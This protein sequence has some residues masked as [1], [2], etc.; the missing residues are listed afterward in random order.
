MREN[1]YE[2]AA[3]LFSQ[4]FHLLIFLYEA[5]V[6][7]LRSLYFQVVQAHEKLLYEIL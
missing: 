1:L 3:I 4:L 6:A 5:L 2:N 7:L